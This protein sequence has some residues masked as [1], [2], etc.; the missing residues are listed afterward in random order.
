MRFAKS[1]RP[2][3]LFVLLAVL[4]AVLGALS[5]HTVSALTIS[6]GLVTIDG[7]VIR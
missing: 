2:A 1:F 3:G 6:S 4:L 5:A 7:I